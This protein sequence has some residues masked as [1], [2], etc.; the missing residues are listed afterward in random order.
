MSIYTQENRIILA[1]E[2]IWT[3]WKKFSQRAA[4]RMYDIPQ[5]TFS[6]RINNRPERKKTRVKQRKLYLIEKQMFV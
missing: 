6:N 3:S 5:A 4:A 1:I 2:A